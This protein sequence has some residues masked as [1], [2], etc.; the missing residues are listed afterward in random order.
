M[1][2]RIFTREQVDE[3]SRNSSVRRCSERSITYDH[4]FKMLAVKKYEDEGL[5]AAQI[6]REAGFDLDVIGKDAPN[7][8]MKEWRRIFKAKGIEGLA[9]ETRGRSGRPKTKGVADA[10]KIERLEATVAYLKA[11]N[12]FL[13]RLRAR[14]T[15]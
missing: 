6:F 11:E 2:K 1:S 4:E 12:A 14:R 8:Q 7:Y 15:E 10:D 9:A 5:G 3:L 13:A